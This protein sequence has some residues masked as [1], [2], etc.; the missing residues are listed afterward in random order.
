[1]PRP[2]PRE[3]RERVV[4]AYNNGEGTYAELA[5][6]FDV[7]EAS[8]SR[9]LAAAR[10]GSLASKPLGGKRHEYK[11]GPEAEQLLRDTIKDVPD[12]TASELV[13]TLRE[14]LG[15]EVSPRTVLRALHRLGLTRKRG[16]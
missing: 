8:V 6:R 5:E 1:M 13:R 11:I 4:K 16:R 12:S 7:G 2:L 3:I 14:E 10:R 15:L 9:Y